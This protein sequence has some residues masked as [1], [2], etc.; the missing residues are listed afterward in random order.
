MVVAPARVYASKRA[1]VVPEEVRA[2]IQGS[3]VPSIVCSVVGVAADI[4]VKGS[5]Q[6]FRLQV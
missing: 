3:L 4:D 5:V 6:N 1:R 2:A